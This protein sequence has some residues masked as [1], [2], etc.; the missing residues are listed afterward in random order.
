MK[1]APGRSPGRAH[2]FH[3]IAKTVKRGLHFCLAF[4]CDNPISLLYD[5]SARLMTLDRGSGYR[6]EIAINEFF[7]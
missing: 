6:A 4:P 5:R 1:A 7:L 2:V 3:Q